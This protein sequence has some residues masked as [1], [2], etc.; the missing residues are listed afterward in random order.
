VAKNSLVV[1]VPDMGPAPGIRSYQA[2]LLGLLLLAIRIGEIKE[3][4]HQDEANAMRQ[5]LIAL[6]DQVEA[7]IQVSE[8][9]VRRAVELC[10]DCPMMMFLGSGPNFG[11]AMFSAAKAVEAAGVFAVAQ[12]LEEWAHVERFCYPNDMPIFIVA[13]PGRSRWRAVEVA[14]TAKSLGHRLVAVIR[15]GDD[16][17]GAYA[18][19]VLPVAGD[20]REEFSPLIYHVAANQFASHL[21]DALGRKAF[22]SDNPAFWNAPAASANISVN[23]GA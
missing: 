22:Q 3:R 19:V 9:P 4:Y 14:Q 15:Q 20:V 5:E 1:A 12:D 17:L 11:T 18:D 21:A 16:E 13:P 10:K 6:A 7:T 23:Q 2:S 8:E